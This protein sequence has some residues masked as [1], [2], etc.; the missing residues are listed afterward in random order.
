MVRCGWLPSSLPAR[1]RGLA[2]SRSILAS[3]LTLCMTRYE[4]NTIHTVPCLPT[5]QGAHQRAKQHAELVV[6]LGHRVG[7]RGRDS[8][9]GPGL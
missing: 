1:E 5:R 9:G 3:V 8:T 2:K 4:C 6:R 7:L